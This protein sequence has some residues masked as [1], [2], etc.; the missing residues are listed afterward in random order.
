M[1]PSSLPESALLW[2]ALGNKCGKYQTGANIH[3][4]D[5]TSNIDARYA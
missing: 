1:K 3:V 4:F 5:H 2:Q